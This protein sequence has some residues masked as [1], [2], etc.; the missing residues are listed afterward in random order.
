[1]SSPALDQD[2]WQIIDERIV[3]DLVTR[4]GAS[5]V[6]SSLIGEKPTAAERARELANLA[7]QGK[8]NAMRDKAED[9]RKWSD[10]FGLRRIGNTLVELNRV[11]SLPARGKAILHAQALTR[12]LENAAV[13]DVD[14]L[15]SFVIGGR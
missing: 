2:V 15:K 13:E 12:F 5:E 4:K 3:D 6:V 8:L 14:M 10:K 7:V 11:I 9:F 1:M